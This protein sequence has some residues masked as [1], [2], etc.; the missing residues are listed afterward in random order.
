MAICDLP[1]RKAAVLWTFSIWALRDSLLG[2]DD[3]S[4][5]APVPSLPDSWTD[6]ADAPPDFL[7]DTR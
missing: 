1:G 3:S 2:E 5:P 4:S 6:D 7:L